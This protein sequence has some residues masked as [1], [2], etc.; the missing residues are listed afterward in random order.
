MNEWETS[1]IK[2]ADEITDK[3]ER[4][5]GKPIKGHQKGLTGNGLKWIAIL[6]M[7]ID[8]TAVALI[9]NGIFLS[10]SI[11]LTQEQWNMWYRLY[12]VMRY[13]G[14]LGFPLFCFLL[15]EGFCYTHNVKKYMLRLG[16]FALISEIP[17]DFAL[18]RSVFYMRYQNVYFTLLI[19][20]ITLC[21]IR[22]FGR[23]DFKNRILRT[24]CLFGGLAAAYVLRTDYDM[25][26]VLLIVVLYLFREKEIWRDLAAGMVLLLNSLVEI[27][28]LLAFVPMHFYNG[29]RGRQMKYFF[30]IFYP[31]HLLVLGLIAKYLILG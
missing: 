17:F 3:W 1:D 26:G 27:T 9:Q 4:S 21:G 19:G 12:W 18:F 15:V 29:Q 7:L 2:Q 10:E 8:H 11:V 25:Y 23:T 31:A 28:G 20:V 24:L 30:Y 6:T 13:I 5:D 16:I 22:Y 14:R